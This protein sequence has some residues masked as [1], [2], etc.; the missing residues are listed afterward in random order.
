MIDSELL[1]YLIRI[2]KTLINHQVDFIVVGGAAVNHYGYNRPSGIGS[3]RSSLK[4]DLDFWYRPTVANYHKLLR[5]LDELD[6]DTTDL[7]QLVF[8]K[9]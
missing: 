8:D 1:Q 6:V 2:S 7:K 9:H 4:V 3:Y 5:A